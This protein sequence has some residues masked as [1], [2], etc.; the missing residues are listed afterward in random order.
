MSKIEKLVASTLLIVVVIVAS[1][2]VN[3]ESTNE[4][5]RRCE[6]KGGVYKRLYKSNN[7]CLRPE[8]LI[9]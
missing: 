8:A 5:Q 9:E 2:A 1:I 6:S 7:L 4:N 3:C